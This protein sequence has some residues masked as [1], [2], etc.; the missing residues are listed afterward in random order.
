VTTRKP[1]PRKQTVWFPV[2]C[3]DGKTREV[4]EAQVTLWGHLKEMGF[5]AVYE[6]QFALEQG[7][8][9]A[10][11]LYVPEIRCGF[12][13]DG[14][15]AGKHGAGWG[16][17][18]EKINL[19]QAL[20]FRCFQFHNRMALNGKAKEWLKVFLFASEAA[21]ASNDHSGGHS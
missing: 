19:A 14:H 3:A 1:K 20:G 8:K 13:L 15:F 21:N 6:Y 17:G 7:R 9:F 18:H 16:E 2:V 11:D 5:E 4:S 10:F 12:E